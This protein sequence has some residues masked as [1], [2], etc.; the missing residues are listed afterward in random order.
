MWG[1]FFVPILALFY[2]ASQV[3]LSQFTLIMSVF[4]LS[5]L[6]LEIPTGVLADLFGKKRTLLLSRFCYVIEI[7]LIAFFNGFWIFLVAKIISGAGVSL[8]SGTNSALLY[9]TL[10]KQ[11]REKEH[12]RISGTLETVTSISMAFVFIIGAFLFSINYKLPAIVSLPL[13]SLGF[14]LTFFLKE[15]YKPKKSLTIKNS[16]NHLIKSLILFSKSDFMKYIA[17]FSLFFLLGRG[18]RYEMAFLSIS[19]SFLV[20]ASFSREVFFLLIPIIPAF[21]WFS[22][23]KRRILYFL[24]PI[25]LVVSI[26]YLPSFF[27]KNGGNLLVIKLFLMQKKEP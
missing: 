5:I 8:S 27:G 2:I 17:L 3:S 9:D 6:I 13:I 14:I 25:I 20:L 26:F 1:R 23:K 11:G 7:F 19:A 16:W 24:A 21:F 12:K 4:S 15:P 18:K 22:G 10:K